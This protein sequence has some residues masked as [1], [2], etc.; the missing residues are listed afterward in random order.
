MQLTQ[1]LSG[2]G[3]A[4]FYTIAWEYGALLEENPGVFNALLVCCHVMKL[5]STTSTTFLVSGLEGSSAYRYQLT[6]FT[7]SYNMLYIAEHKNIGSALLMQLSAK[8]ISALMQYDIV[9]N[10]A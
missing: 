6:A 7:G 4:K 3:I 1:P 2:D 5:T 9:I 8:F 10:S